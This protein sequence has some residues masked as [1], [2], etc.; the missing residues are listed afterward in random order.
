MWAHTSLSSRLQEKHHFVQQTVSNPA[1]LGWLCS[2]LAGG[3]PLPFLT[4][5]AHHQPHP[6]TDTDAEPCLA[7]FTHMRW[8][9]SC[10]LTNGI[11]VRILQNEISSD[12]GER[13]CIE[14][15]RGNLTAFQS[16]YQS[17]CGSKPVKQ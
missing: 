6:L 14:T 8:A 1:A 4:G 7:V 11:A 15:N 9:I 5:A 16:S 13:F 17:V 2:L 3:A 12:A 10:S